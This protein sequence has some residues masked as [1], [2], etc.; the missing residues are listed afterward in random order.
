MVPKNTPRYYRK[1]QV[2]LYTRQSFRELAW[3]SGTKNRM[4]NVAINVVK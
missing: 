1:A 4:I 3:K 2:M